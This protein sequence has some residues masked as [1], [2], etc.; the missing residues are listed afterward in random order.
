MKK[1]VLETTA[2]FQGL[3]ELVA[4][5]EGLF[6]KEGLKIEWVERESADKSTDVDVNSPKGLDPF[7]SHGK[8]LEQGKADMYNACEWGNYCRVQ[9]TKVGSRQVGRRGIVTY[10]AH[11]GAA[12][13]GGVHRAAA[14]RTRPSACRSTSAR[15]ISRCICSKASCR[16]TRSGSCRTSNGSRAALRRHDEGRGRGDD[17]DRALRHARRKEGL[18]A[19]LRGVL[20]RHRGGVG[21]GRRR[22]LRRVQPRGARGGAA[23]QRRQG[24]RTCTTSSTIT[25]RKDAEIAALTPAG[26][27]REPHRGVRSGADP[28]RRDA[29]HL[30]VAQELGHAGA[31]RDAARA[32]QSQGAAAPRTRSRRSSAVRKPHPVIPRRSRAKRGLEGCGRVRMRQRAAVHFEARASASSASA[33]GESALPST[34]RSSFPV[35]RRGRHIARHR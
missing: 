27:A 26:P 19:D 13:F 5:D 25:R 4:Y 24:A 8:M 29:A 30:R 18:P 20:S 32:G 15:T 34:D 35:R 6:A 11:R 22:D 9:D 1:L 7:S 28:A 12:G 2:P 14:R 16:A 10:A 3:P 31:D 17:A 23:D 33:R 21:P